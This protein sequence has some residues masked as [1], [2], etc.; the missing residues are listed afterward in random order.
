MRVEFVDDAAVD[1]GDMVDGRVRQL[2][3]L[4]HGELDGHG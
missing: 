4:V 2:R 3:Y 1:L